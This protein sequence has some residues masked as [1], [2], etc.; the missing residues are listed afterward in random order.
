MKTQFAT[1]EITVA[2][3]ELGFDDF[4]MF[5]W[6]IK[7]DNTNFG[8]TLHTLDDN[9]FYFNPQYCIAAPLWQQVIE[10]FRE[11]HQII[12][13][14]YGYHKF[15]SVSEVGQIIWDF[16]VWNLLEMNDMSD[17]TYYY[18]YEDAREA[19]ILEVITLLKEENNYGK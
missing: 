19:A 3:R 14:I 5:G 17:H 18:S 6:Y 12:I 7:E 13:D 11:E 1:Y 10:W 8:K 16:S 9:D 15:N 4:E 2:L